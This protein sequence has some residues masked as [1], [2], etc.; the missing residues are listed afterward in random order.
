VGDRIDERVLLFG[1]SNLADEKVVLRM[2][3]VMMAAKTMTPRRSGATC[4]QVITIQP[5]FRATARATSD[6]PN[7]TKKAIAPRRPGATDIAQ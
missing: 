1:S 5:T 3:P 4:R 6:T 2:R 7:V